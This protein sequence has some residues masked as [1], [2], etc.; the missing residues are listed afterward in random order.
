M[1]VWTYGKQL[2]GCASKISIQMIQKF[3]NK[4][5]RIIMDAP[6]YVGDADLQSVMGVDPVL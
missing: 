6:W 1:P 3:Q 5:L 4:A 2:W